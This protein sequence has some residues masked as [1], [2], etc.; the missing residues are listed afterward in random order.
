MT[1]AVLAHVPRR[2]CRANPHFNRLVKGDFVFCWLTVCECHLRSLFD[3]ESFGL[4]N[5]FLSVCTFRECF[6]RPKRGCL[7]ISEDLLSEF[8]RC[9]QHHGLYLFV[10]DR[11]H[12][13]CFWVGRASLPSVGQ[14]RQPV[15]Y[16]SGVCYYIVSITDLWLKSA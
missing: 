14:S 16:I 3:V 10:V 13:C 4:V 12:V 11:L 6:I 9:I 15:K 1:V 2:P 7:K 5:Q 8:H